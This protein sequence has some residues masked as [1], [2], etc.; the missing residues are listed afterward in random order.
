MAGDGEA[1]NPAKAGDGAAID[2]VS[3]NIWP[4]SQRTQDAVIRLLAGTLS[5][6]SVLTKRYGVVPIEEASAMARLIEQE[7]FAV[8]HSDATGPKVLQ[9][10][11]KEIS[12]RAIDSVESRASVVSFTSF[13][14]VDSAPAETASITDGAGEEAASVEPSSGQNGKGGI[15][16]RWQK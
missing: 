2:A 10:Y 15:H 1:A 6:P 13:G 3:F 5:S 12:N 8:A 4:P 11:S 14:D 16:R 7:A 9:I